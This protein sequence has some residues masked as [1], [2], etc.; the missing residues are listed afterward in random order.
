MD[1]SAFMHSFVTL[2]V[3]MDPFGGLPVFMTLTKDYSP[4]RQQKS[5]HRAIRVSFLLLTVFVF[6]GKGVLDFF[7]ISLFSFQVGGGLILLIIGLMYVLNINQ[8]EDVNYEK[9]IVVPMATPLIAGPG[10]ITAIILL[11][12]QYGIL[13]PYVA[14][15][16]NL[17]IFWVAMYYARHINKALGEQGLEIMSRIMGLLLVALAIEMIR[18][19]WMELL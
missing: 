3:I 11:V 10:A 19:A 1:L 12:A 18:T 7:S 13:V 14:M 5:A 9:D 8:H 17:V 2:L 15:I 6:V 4:E 16:A